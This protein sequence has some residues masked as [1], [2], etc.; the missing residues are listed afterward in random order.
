MPFIAW[1]LLLSGTAWAQQAANKKPYTD[2]D[3]ASYYW[4]Y[5]QWDSAFK[6]YSSYVS[7]T[8]GGGLLKASAYKF[9]GEIS[10]NV[11]DYYAAQ[12]YLNA[13]LQLLDPKDTAHQ[14]E[15]G[16]VYNI[17]GNVSLE[18]NAYKEAIAYYDQALRHA[19]NSTYSS[20][21]LNGKATALQK[22]KNFPAAMAVYDQ[23]LD[24][25]L[26]DMPLKARVIDN[27]AYT[28]W[29]QNNAYNPLPEFSRAL[30]IRQDSQYVTGIITSYSHLADYYAINN[31]DSASWYALQM[32]DKATEIRSTRDRKDA[33]DKLV[34]LQTDA[35]GKEKWFRQYKLLSDSLT[36]ANDTTRY[37]FANIR[38][39]VEKN[40]ADNL[41]LKD[42]LLKQRVGM[43]A[44]AFLGLLIIGGLTIRYRKKR[45]AIQQQSDKAIETAKL[46]TSQ[47]VHDVVANGLYGIM[48]E[49]EHSDTL[50]KEPL[51]TKIELLYER[52][53][54]ISYEDPDLLPEGGYDKRVQQLLKSLAGEH[55]RLVVVGN[56]ASFWNR[57]S[58]AQQQQLFLVLNELMVNM[59]KHSGAG[60]V[61]VVFK[62]ED[63][64]AL[65]RYK[66]NGVGM[67]PGQVFGNGLASTVNRIKSIHGAINFGESGSDGTTVVISFPVE[68]STI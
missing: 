39:A 17:L 59:K 8:K 40:K 31:R 67:A 28:A 37:R 64:T 45:Q 13:A 23:L 1:L 51:L 18:L 11:G 43:A 16:Y 20:E 66:D 60:N 47:K 12:D 44:L 63:N 36:F 57:I 30:Q 53:R 35:A 14:E 48:N 4:H 58:I 15:L 46:K 54:D 38:Y 10:W 52:S 34:S 2:F 19:G 25:N 29:L 5:D 49:L 33:I 3:R 62:I 68:P 65:V 21:I 6:Y 56:E 61:S 24:R 32:Y 22:E 55:T 41:V 9:Q 27:R 50:D 7:N 26:T 42:N